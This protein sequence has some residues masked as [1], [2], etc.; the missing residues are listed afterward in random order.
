[1]IDQLKLRHIVRHEGFDFLGRRSVLMLEPTHNTGW[2]WG[3][4]GKDIPITPDIMMSKRRRV[5]LVYEGSELNE[6]EHIGVLRATGLRN[7]RVWCSQTWPPYDGGAFAL[8]QAVIPHVYKE[9]IL[10]PYRAPVMLESADLEEEPGRYS[11]YSGTGND[12]DVLRMTGGV[13]FLR[14]HPDYYRFGHMYPK[15]DLL[16]LVRARTLGWP[17]SLRNASWLASKLGWPHHE[18][19]LWPQDHF[20]AEVLA[21]IGRH[22]LLDALAIINFLAPAGMY[23][24]G[25]FHSCKGNHATDLELL[26][27]LSAGKVVDFKRNAA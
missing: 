14:I 23:L 17:P 5:A 16:P 20:A 10:E 12:Y 13:E 15:D 24:A 3:T 2:I 22:R 4:G 9:G 25:S 8:W 1:M 6:F 26:K 18:R 11:Q 7:V 21:E 27:K 19:I